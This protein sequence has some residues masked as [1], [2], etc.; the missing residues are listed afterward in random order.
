MQ[1]RNKQNQMCLRS[2]AHFGHGRLKRMTQAAIFSALLCLLSP[3][4]LPFSTVP[5]SLA[6]FAVALTALLL[7]PHLSLVSVLVYLLLGGVGLPVFSGFSG[8]LGVLLGPTGGY[9]LTYPLVTL[10][11]GLFI[12]RAKR[13]WTLAA[14]GCLLALVV[15]YAGGTAWY[16]FVTGTRK[17]GAAML[18]CVYPFVIG[19][20]LKMVAA[21]CLTY[22]VR[23]R[24]KTN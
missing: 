2:Q 6:L 22:L 13:F 19:D 20:V 9:L 14:C 21:C 4:C 17:I 3:V 10:I 15:C 18:V 11:I 16:M 1:K 23:R 7:P 12:R 8:G 5:F 24:L